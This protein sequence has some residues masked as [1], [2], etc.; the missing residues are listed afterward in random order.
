[1]GEKTT[2]KRHDIHLQICKGQACERGARQA[3]TTPAPTRRRG[4]GLSVSTADSSQRT[5]RAC[6]DPG[7]PFYTGDIPTPAAQT[8]CRQLDG[9]GR[10][11][12]PEN[13]KLAFFFSPSLSTA[14]TRSREG[15]SCCLLPTMKTE[16][17]RKL[18][19]QLPGV[20]D[21]ATSLP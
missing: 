20:L 11:A 3:S 12:F 21:S 6:Q 4:L 1:M 13:L 19:S 16:K 7:P 15:T 8:R 18:G 14:C 17:H 2:Q 10:K 5:C 9:A